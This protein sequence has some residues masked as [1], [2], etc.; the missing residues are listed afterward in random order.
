ME[1][2]PS[3][4]ADPVEEDGQEQV[5]DLVGDEDA[6]QHG[7][8]HRPD[9]LGRHAAGPEHRRQADDDGPLGQQLGPE[10]VDGAV[11]HGLPQVV[12]ADPLQAAGPGDGL[13]EVDQHDDPGRG[14]HAEAGDVADPDRDRELQAQQPLEEEAAGDRAGHRQHH[15]RGVGQVVIGPVE[16]HEDQDDDDRHDQRERPPRAELVLELAG[17]LEED[18]VRQP[19]LAGDGGAALRRRGRRRRDRGHS[20]RT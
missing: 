16:D 15:Q 1:P 14:R 10:A 8:G 13:A 9:D 7:R 4:A 20:S 5:D 6:A 19:G 18:A 11:Q 12:Q 17:P 2:L 3:S